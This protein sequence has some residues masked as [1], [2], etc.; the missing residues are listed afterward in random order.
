VKQPSLRSRPSTS[1]VTAIG[2]QALR[3]TTA[4][5][6]GITGMTG[7]GCTLLRTDD[8][9][10]RVPP[11]NCR[12]ALESGEHAA[13][14]PLRS[15]AP[16]RVV[17]VHSLTLLLHAPTHAPQRRVLR[18]PTVDAMAACGGARS[19]AAGDYATKALSAVHTPPHATPPLA[20][21][22]PRH[23]QY[24]KWSPSILLL[25][26]DSPTAPPTTLS[27]ND[28]PACIKTSS[29]HQLL[30]QSLASHRSG[31]GGRLLCSTRLLVSPTPPNTHARIRSSAQGTAAL[32]QALCLPLVPARTDTYILLDL[33]PL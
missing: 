6:T 10:S 16:I 21:T 24:S 3:S 11:T 29:G 30:S 2:V 27:P 23:C 4:A 15:N 5:P 32:G 8:N 17:L 7:V 12:R 1:K 13:H 9:L 14:R 33:L 18:E 25:D 22:A 26:T 19:P 31:V 20:A 28:V